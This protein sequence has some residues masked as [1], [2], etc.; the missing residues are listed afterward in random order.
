MENKARWGPALWS[1]LH[2]CTERIGMIPSN[3]AEEVKIWTVFLL[4]LQ[5]NLPCV[6]C[7]TH[8]AAYYQKTGPP[9]I[10]KEGVRRWLYELHS[11]VNKR[12]GKA[13]LEYDA[14]EPLYSQPFDFK[15]MVAIIKTQLE[16]NIRLKQITS[17]DMEK[18]IKELNDFRRFYHLI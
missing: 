11:D 10:T 17:A 9:V 14:L 2:H 7:Q 8:Y 1:I 5:K 3:S 16:Y 12:L 15:Q 4:H 18:F 6:K 13:N